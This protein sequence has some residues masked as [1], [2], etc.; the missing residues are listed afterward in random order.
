M[1]IR[2]VKRLRL[3]LVTM[4]YLSTK[5][6]WSRIARSFRLS[7]N[8]LSSSAPDLPDDIVISEHEPLWRSLPD[9]AVRQGNAAAIACGRFRF[10]GLEQVYASEPLWHD[11]GVSRLWR[12]QLHGF[13]Y[14]LDLAAAGDYATFKHLSES[15]MRQNARIGGDGWHPYTVSQRIVNWCH[16]LD[17]FRDDFGRDPSFERNLSRSTYAQLRYLFRNIEFDVRGNHILENLRALIWGG[18]FFAGQEPARWLD[19]A[20]HIM[21]TEVTEQ[22][23]SDG[24]HFER[25]PTYHVVVLRLLLETSIWLER[26]RERPDWLA[27]SV[28]RMLRFLDAIVMA[29]GNLPLLKDTTYD[30][31]PPN[32]VLA[33]GAVW[34]TD[35]TLK[36][37][38]SATSY[39]VLL[40]GEGARR[41]L[42]AMPRNDAPRPTCFLEDSLLACIRDDSDSLV[43][44]VG[45]PCPDYLP[46]HAH[47]DMFSFELVAGG[48]RAI[49]DSGVYV[50]EAGVWRDHFRSTRAHNTVEVA[51]EDQSEV[52]SSFRVARRARPCN[53]HFERGDGFVLVQAEQDGYERLPVAVR[54]RRTMVWLRRVLV[55]IDDLCGNGTTEAI[56]RVQ[57]H[58]SFESTS[59]HV[60]T[61]GF[62][63][64]A[65]EQ[66]WYSEH[67]GELAAT[68]VLA[69]HA[70][71]ML[72][73][74]F[75]YSIAHVPAELS[76]DHGLIRLRG[77][78]DA[79]IDPDRRSV[80]FT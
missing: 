54:H 26:N 42:E 22:I 13:D 10:L 76:S 46:A 9:D 11:A 72:P 47:A 18:L 52:W 28:S 37:S 51:G 17:A 73:L 16:A 58:P 69:A 56:S 60:S 77:A 43:I 41:T 4:S 3:F 12:Y 34:R 20:L 7:W 6:I 80:S 39:A 48:R 23:L 8:R 29:D 68:R 61:F 64:V 57:W 1:N 71:G 38:D 45:P 49:V 50:Y 78:V 5:Q 31:L 53:M 67:F 2:R 27:D 59:L 74:R 66:G 32:D 55:V 62:A 63:G 25:T 24:G 19:R 30:G 15:W 36:R 75:G 21:R 40:F 33:A 35:A 70:A 14:V 79:A 65:E 44:D